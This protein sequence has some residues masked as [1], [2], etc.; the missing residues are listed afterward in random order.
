[1]PKCA[2]S[3][4][5]CALLCAAARFQ[6]IRKRGLIYQLRLLMQ[7]AVNVRSLNERK[8]PSDRAA[9]HKQ[10]YNGSDE[11]RGVKAVEHTAMR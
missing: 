9:C 11:E 10:I 4:A 7:Q 2:H 5:L 8:A 3:F 1:M 6:N